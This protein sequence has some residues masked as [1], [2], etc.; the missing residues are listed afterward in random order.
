MI[1]WFEKYKILFI[2]ILLYNNN[3]NNNKIK[4]TNN[5]NIIIRNYTSTTMYSGMY[6]VTRNSKSVPSLP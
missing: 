5:N 6:K 4:N 3:N 2:I 1:Y